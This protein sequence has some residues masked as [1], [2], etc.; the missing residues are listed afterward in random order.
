MTWDVQVTSCARVVS[1][2]PA[3]SAR[4]PMLIGTA[5]GIVLVIIE[6]N[7]LCMCS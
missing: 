6:M 7:R 5:L 4:D 2:L 3:T 1:R